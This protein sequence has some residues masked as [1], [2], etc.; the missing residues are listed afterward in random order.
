MNIPEGT[1]LECGAKYVGWALENPNH[2]HCACG[3]EL[4][5]EEKQ[6]EK[7]K[8]GVKTGAHRG[9]YERR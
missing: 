3:G 1:C 4:K 8:G 2:G 6:S 5:L 7:N 9:T